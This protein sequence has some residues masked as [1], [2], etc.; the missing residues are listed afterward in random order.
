MMMAVKK[1][2]YKLIQEDELKKLM[3]FVT[4]EERL[5]L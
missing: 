2:A 1:M 4:K 5:E 3:H